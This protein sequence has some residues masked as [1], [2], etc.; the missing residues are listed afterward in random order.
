MTDEKIILID[1]I[2]WVY[3]SILLFAALGFGIYLGIKA[4]FSKDS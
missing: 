3:Y 2:L 4:L 1:T